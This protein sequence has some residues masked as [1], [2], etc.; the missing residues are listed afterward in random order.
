MSNS[1]S[2]Y[3][4]NSPPDLTPAQLITW[5]RQETFLRAF[6]TSGT[7]LQA[8]K[9]AGIHRDSVYKWAERDTLDFKHRLANARADFSESVEDIIFTRIQDPKCNPL[10]LMFVAKAHNREKY[11]DS[12]VV[13]N[14]RAMELLA[15]VRALPAADGVVLEGEII[16]DGRE[17]VELALGHASGS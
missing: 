16:P 3:T 5:N 13:K 11:G 1:K 2:V 10:L 7:I 12:I 15:A 4:S 8:A 9:A 14:D 17:Q 6:S